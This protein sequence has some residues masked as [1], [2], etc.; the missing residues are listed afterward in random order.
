MPGSPRAILDASRA[1]LEQQEAALKRPGLA[2]EL[3]QD[4]RTR[5]D[6][7][8]ERLRDL[9]AE[10]GPQLDSARARLE[11]LGPRP[12]EGAPPEGDDVARDR[13]GREAGVAEVDEF[14]R[15][16]RALLLQAEQLTAQISDRRRTDFTRALF[17]RGYSVFS[18]DLWL[19]TAESLPRD[20]R[21]LR[22]VADDALTRIAGRAS[23]ATLTILGLAIGV[24]TA[25]YLARRHVAPRLIRRA[26]GAV[27]VNRR[28]KLLAAA[29]VLLIEVLPAAVGS[30]LVYQLLLIADL[31]PPRLY[32]VVAAILTGLVFT[33]FLRAA[34][35]SLLAAERPAWR[36]VG[37]SDASA[38]RMT[39]FILAFGIV[40]ATGKVLDALNQAIAAALPLAVA[41]RAV[42]V[43][44]AALILAELLRR[45]AVSVTRDETCLGPYVAS[46]PDAGG[47]IRILGWAVI[48]VILAGA[49]AGY[50]AFASFLTDQVAWIASL[51]FVLYLGSLLVDEFVAGTLRGQTGIATTLQANLG[52]RRRS[53]EQL[54]VVCAGAGRVLLVILAA[55]LALAPWGVESGD[56]ASNL[57]AAFFGFQV[58]EVTI[59]LSTTIGA[60]LLFG[61]VIAA[62][63]ILQSWLSNTFLPT[64]ELDS[65]L[66]NSILT[67]AGYLGF[68]AAAAIGFAHLGVGLDKIAIVAGALSVGIG[69]GLQSIVNNFVSGLI[70]LWER[71]I[72][73]GDLVVIGDGEGYVRRISVRA[74]EIETFDRASVIVPNSNLISGVVKNRVRGDKLGRVSVTVNVPRDKDP[75]RAA[76]ILVEHAARHPDVLGEPPPRAFFKTIGDANL[77]FEL[78]C[79]IDD[80][81]SRL[82][83][84]SELN[85]SVFGAL[86][87][88]GIIPMPGPPA[89]VNLAGLEPVRGALEQ[90]AESI[91]KER[92]AG[93]NPSTSEF[94]ERR[95]SSAAGE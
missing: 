15:I 76:A 68:F 42:F 48:G 74:T 82:R 66:R 60:L 81:S 47:P 30:F 87:A 32:P 78:V 12:K 25:F 77:E 53:L 2:A 51:A 4:L 61:L 39:T 22:I 86:A 91:A 43:T 72:R 93:G 52:L 59:S 34:L 46:E 23:P 17:Q 79:I 24:A 27:E 31:L 33:A 13:A 57:R 26:R 5:I 14:H 10:L 75:V 18:P 90:I 49:G 21:A 20:V 55:M 36:L 63:R 88:E 65:G 9:I 8:T 50:V 67:A 45:F 58:G 54:G 38:R 73:V 1:E 40:V 44:I 94:P 95:R 69:F 28:R 80:V 89:P 37:V 3:L 64:T 19:R 83:V 85:F 84:Q 16:A 62:T 11:Q 29:G 6:P 71:P 41:T 7:V 92:R 70:L 56:I 35:D